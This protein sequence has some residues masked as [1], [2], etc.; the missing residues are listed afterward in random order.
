[1]IQWLYVHFGI[2]GSGSWYGFWSGAGSDLGELAILGGMVSIYRKHTCHVQ[3]CWRFGKHP[4]EGT[5]YTTCRKH[6]PD[7]EGEI[8]V[9]HIRIAHQIARLRDHA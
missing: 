2:A 5:C 7:I 1:M 3:S 8:T 6:H 9:H 4:V